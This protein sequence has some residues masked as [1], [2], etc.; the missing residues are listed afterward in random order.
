MADLRLVTGSMDARE[1][2]QTR[3]VVGNKIIPLT[4]YNMT[5][6]STTSKKEWGAYGNDCDVP[7]CM[8]A[9]RCAF[10]PC[11]WLGSL[12]VPVRLSRI[13]LSSLP[14]PTAQ[15]VQMQFVQDA[16]QIELPSVRATT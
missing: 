5:Y 1:A 11:I 6:V 14:V 8:D 9:P 16:L 4:E 12:P 15:P 2:Y 3:Y 13:S 10:L 7:V